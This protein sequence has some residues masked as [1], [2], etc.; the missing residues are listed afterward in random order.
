VPAAEETDEKPANSDR[1]LTNAGKT[2]FTDD[3]LSSF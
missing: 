2:K 3:A 1:I